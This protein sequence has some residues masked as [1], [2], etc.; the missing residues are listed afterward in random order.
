[1]RKFHAR[2]MLLGLIVAFALIPREAVNGQNSIRTGASRGTLPHQDQRYLRD[3]ETVRANEQRKPGS[4]GVVS[5]S[6][7]ASIRSFELDS[8]NDGMPDSW[9]LANGLNP[10]DPKDAWGD[11]DGDGIVNLFEYQLGANPRISSSPGVVTV[12]KGQDVGTAIDGA[13]SGSVIRV[14]GGDY[15]VNYAMSSGKV[16]MIQGGWNSTFTQRDVQLF[17]TN[18]DGRLQDAILYFS[19]YSQ[20]GVVI[21]DGL[22]LRN[23]KDFLG[24][25][26][27][28]SDG[29]SLA[30][31][32]WSMLDCLITSSETSSG[33]T[34]AILINHWG[35]SEAQVCIAR[36]VIAGNKT[37]G[38]Y[39]QTTEQSVARWRIIN[40]TISKNEGLT[41]SDEG[42]GIRGFTLDSAALNISIRNTIVWGNQKSDLDIDRSITAAVDYSDVGTVNAN[43]GAS[44]IAG[45]GVMNRDPLLQD[46]ANGNFRLTS[47]SPCINAG[48]DVGFP[49]AGASPDIGAYEYASSAEPFL[50]LNTRDISFGSVRVGQYKDTTFTI[51]NVGTDTLKISDIAAS[52]SVFGIRPTTRT[53]PPA[54]SFLDTVRFTPAVGGSVTAGILITSNASTSPDTVNVSGSGIAG[55]QNASLRPVAVGPFQIGAPFWIEVRVGDPNP[56]AGLYGISFKLKSDKATCTYVDGSATTGAFLGT[57]PLAFFQKVDPQTVDMGITKTS[58]PGVSGGGVVAKAQFV[59]TVAGSVTFSLAGVSAM[60]QNGVAI[61]LDTSSAAIVFGVPGIPKLQLSSKDISFG[62]VQVGQFKDTTFTITNVGTDTLK[63]SDIAASSSVFGARPTIRKILPGES[64]SDTLRFTPVVVETAAG[65]ILVTSNASSSVDTIVVSGAGVSAQRDASLRPFGGPC[66]V[67]KAFWVEVRVGDPNPVAGLYGLSFKLKSDNATCTY[68]DGSATAGSFLG[69]SPLSFFQKVDQQ[70][71]DMGISKT[72]PPGVSGGGVVAKAQFVA[73]IPGTVWFSLTELSAIDQ[74]G[75]NIVMNVEPLGVTASG[76]VS[77]GAEADNRL[78]PTESGLEQNYPNPFNPSTM[79][80]F[81]IPRASLVHL[82]IYSALGIEIAALVGTHLSA[83]RY[84]VEWNANNLPS[85]VYFCRLQ[86]DEFVKTRRL[87][88]LR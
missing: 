51:T 35:N 80:Q 48:I 14:E 59:S 77:V 74:T 27:F 67:G 10:N 25:V 85:G 60:D 24:S 13:S 20:P 28:I 82:K 12:A 73:T 56:V 5:K 49:F 36:S 58:P 87:I 44:Y 16:I 83:G 29:T 6:R 33:F 75:T 4:T 50:Q 32:K 70:T 79:I 31:V 17:P 81:D 62:N 37:S 71:V 52:N 54:Q 38:I 84:R 69:V 53:I 7:L 61:P 43:G 9:E 68:V 88:L 45:S 72:S 2:T 3:L 47:A 1:M 18:F 19:F 76:V 41:A 40:G 39:N 22:N 55:Q 11:P 66:E 65:K 57:S 42:H 64:F 34:G 78:I 63:I 30:K 15:N 46:A 8:D 23:G 26:V 21:L 86:T